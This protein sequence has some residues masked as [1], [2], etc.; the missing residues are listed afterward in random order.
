LGTASRPGLSG[1]AA[2]QAELGQDASLA[3]G[4]HQNAENKAGH[5]QASNQ[6][7]GPRKESLAGFRPMSGGLVHRPGFGPGAANSQPLVVAWGIFVVG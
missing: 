7:F 6:H 4:L 5:G 2:G 3:E 1:G